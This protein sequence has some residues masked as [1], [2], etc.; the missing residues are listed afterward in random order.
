VVIKVPPPLQIR[1]QTKQ[2][3]VQIWPSL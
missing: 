1:A 2:K 3:H